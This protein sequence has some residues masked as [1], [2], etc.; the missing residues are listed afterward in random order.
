MRLGAPTAAISIYSHLTGSTMLN[1]LNEQ[2]TKVHQIR[3]YSFC[4]CGYS[5]TMNALNCQ[6]PYL[7]PC[8]CGSRPFNPLCEVLE[9]LWGV[10]GDIR[11]CIAT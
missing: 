11:G 6:R 7:H 10:Q 8:A 9:L 5:G 2:L 3:L 4:P 1:A